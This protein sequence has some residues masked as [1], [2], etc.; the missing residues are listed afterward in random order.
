M[1][2]IR[3]LLTLLLFLLIV[4]STAGNACVAAE[5]EQTARQT[6]L[7][8]TLRKKKLPLEVCPTSNICLGIASNIRDH[9]LPTLV[10]EGLQITI[11]SDDPPLFNTTLTNEYALVADA[12]G[13]DENAIEA[14]VMNAVDACLLNEESKAELRA[15]VQADFALLKARQDG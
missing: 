6:E 2:G 10:A 12:Y 14:F 4:A 15:S 1:S 5:G 9:P 11:N 3:G 7:V 13:Y 8:D